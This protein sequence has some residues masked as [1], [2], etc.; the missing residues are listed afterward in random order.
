MSPA[1]QVDI[2]STH[3]QVLGGPHGQTYFGCHFPADQEYAARLA[4]EGLK[5]GRRLAREGVLG[6][7]AVD[8]VAVRD[9]GAW[10]LNAVEINLRCGGTTHPV[11]RAAGAD[12]RRLRPARRRVP[13]PARRRQA[14]RGHRPPRLAGAT[15][16]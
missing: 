6:R 4:A 7:A 12:R 16:R 10:R 11:L 8:F 2:L 5:V 15:G 9:G 13:H 14:L 1:G 3:D